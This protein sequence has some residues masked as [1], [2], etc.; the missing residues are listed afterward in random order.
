MDTDW[1]AS[2]TTAG[3]IRDIIE[4]APEFPVPIKDWAKAELKVDQ[5]IKPAQ[6]VLQNARAWWELNQ[7]A[8]LAN[9]F[10][11]VRVPTAALAVVPAKEPTPKPITP[12]ADIVTPPE[13]FAPPSAPPAV[14]ASAPIAP[15]P[16]KSTNPL[17]WIVSAI[18]A[19]VA[20]V[21]IV[22]RKKP[23]A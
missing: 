15:P 23:N 21:L 1:G 10:D 19:L 4:R 3:L 17:W 11:Q 14:V 5:F 6:S 2:A 22:R 7:A 9:Q 16:S 12:V 18:A 8:L 20:V 13:P